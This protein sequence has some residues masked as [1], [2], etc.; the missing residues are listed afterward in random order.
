[1]RDGVDQRVK[2]EGRQIRIL[3]LDEHHV[4]CVVPAWTNRYHWFSTRICM[5]NK[6]IDMIMFRTR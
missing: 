3:S 2:V 6:I 4:W 5:N 1:M